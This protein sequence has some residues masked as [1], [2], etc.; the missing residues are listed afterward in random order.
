MSFHFILT[1]LTYWI[2]ANAV[3]LKAG[4]LSVPITVATGRLGNILNLPVFVSSLLLLQ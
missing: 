3:P 1:F 4:I 2:L